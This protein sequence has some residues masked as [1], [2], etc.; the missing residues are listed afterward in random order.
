MRTILLTLLLALASLLSASEGST[1]SAQDVAKDTIRFS[2]TNVVMEDNPNAQTYCFTLYSPDGQ[3]KMQL[4]YWAESMFGTFGNDDFRLT[5]D[6]KYYNFVRNPK[7]DMQF[8]SLTDMDVTVSD[9]GTQY[10]IVG[11]CLASN[12]TRFLVEGFVPVLTPKDTV[13]CDLGYASMVQNSFYGT[14]AFNAANDDFALQYGVVS[15]EPTGNF[16]TADILKPEITDLHTGERLDVKSAK[17]MH[18]AVDG[19]LHLTLE[20]MTSDLTLYR[21]FMQH[22]KRQIEVVREES[23]EIASGVVMQDLTEMY[24]CYQLGAQSQDWAVAIAFVPSAIESGQRDWTMEDI[25]MPY[26]NVVDMHTETFLTIEDIHVWLTEQNKL[27]T[28][29]ADILTPEG[30]LYHFSLLSEGD[31]YM[32]EPTQTIDVDYGHVAMIDYTRG[33]GIVGLGA[34]DPERSQMRLY[35]YAPGLQDGDYTTADIVQDM[36]DVVE[37]KPG[38]VL[39]FH[40]AEYANT[41]IEHDAEGVAHL[42]V[43]MMTTDGTLYHATMHIDPLHCL[44]EGEKYDLTAYGMMIGLQEQVMNDYTIYRLNMGDLEPLYDDPM[45]DG[46]CFDF[47]LAA[48]GEGIG[49]EYSYSEGTLDA[50][51][52]HTIVEHGTEVRIAAEAGTLTLKPCDVITL[53]TDV[54]GEAERLTLNVY[55]VTFRF[56]GQN[57]VIYEGE[58]T[59][60]LYSIDE[61]GEYIRLTE[62]ELAALRSVLAE[63]GYD[64]R[65]VMR[66]GHMLLLTPR[67][68]VR[69]DG[70]RARK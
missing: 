54:I 59:L 51:T 17:A 57:A 56:V 37:V 4:N 63:R 43:D 33:V 69:A 32:P 62:P 36:C 47:R 30:T 16:Y 42:T 6:G 20:T 22:Y 7:N 3:W 12:K 45:G 19:T 26:T 29:H 70:V 44:T 21:F 39:S 9:E 10:R 64:V 55:E 24:G 28:F 66:D 58:D 11:N 15:Q 46:Y 23:V 13:N 14:Y 18:V 8:Y 48:T 60:A 31:G 61:E 1:A 67:G 35:L 40:D 49:G 5:G 34:V 41:H 25:F 2:T 52:S 65:Q 53:D 68:A 27:Y 50:N 38:N